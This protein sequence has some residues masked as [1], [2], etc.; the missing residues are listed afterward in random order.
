MNNLITYNTLGFG[1]EILGQI[2]C[3][4]GLKFQ[5]LKITDSILALTFPYNNQELLLQPSVVKYH[6]NSE[7]KHLAYQATLSAIFS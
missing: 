5:G 6:E 1:L 7:M 2:G 3:W 4:V